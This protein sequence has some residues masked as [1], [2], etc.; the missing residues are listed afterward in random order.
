MA[1]AMVTHM[2]RMPITAMAATPITITA[3]T[4]IT[5]STVRRAAGTIICAQPI[6]MYS[7]MR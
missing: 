1:M 5:A 2:V 3:R 6:C 7:P 4:R